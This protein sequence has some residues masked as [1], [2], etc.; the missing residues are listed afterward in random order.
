MAA[1]VSSFRGRQATTTEVVLARVGLGG[2]LSVPDEPKGM[3]VFAHGSGSSRYSPRN[4]QVAHGLQAAGLATLLF[5]L[6][7]PEEAT[8]EG[9]FNVDLLAERLLLALQW[10][11]GQVALMPLKVGLFGS[12][13][14]AAAALVAAARDVSVTA[15]VSRGGRPDL[16]AAA[17]PDVKAPTLLIV[18]ENDRQVLELN[19]RAFK[20]L[21]GAK[22]LEIVPGATHL[23]E[24]PGALDLVIDHA[25]EWFVS[26][27]AGVG[28]PDLAGV[29]RPD[30]AGV[31][32][33]ES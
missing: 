30:L 15:V 1:E 24:K 2:F 28:R 29:G 18:G 27:L 13:T 7:Q 14:G 16:A 31:G 6:L 26:H 4:T 20:L 10:L 17:L 19:R 33:P 25:R 21:G 12:S 22:R 9:V 3:V 8:R 5:D 11:R 32:R 23:F